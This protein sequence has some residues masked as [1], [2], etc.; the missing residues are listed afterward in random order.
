M[1]ARPNMSGARPRSFASITVPGSADASLSV[2]RSASTVTSRARSASSA[3]HVTIEI[4]DLAAPQGSVASTRGDQSEAGDPTPASTLAMRLKSKSKRFL[5]T[6]IKIYTSF[7]AVS[8]GIKVATNA[9]DVVEAPAGFFL[10]I[11]AGTAR[12][13]GMQVQVSNTAV[14]REYGAFINT[15]TQ[16]VHPTIRFVNTL[17]LDGKRVGGLYER[18]NANAN[19]LDPDVISIDTYNLYL[20]RIAAHEYLHCYTHQNFNNAI[21]D[22]NAG[23]D[24]GTQRK[25]IEG[26]TEY[27]TR[28]TP[29]S[30]SGDPLFV[31]YKAYGDYVKFIKTIVRDI[32]EETLKKAY[33]SGDAESIQKFLEAVRRHSI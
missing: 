33:L 12:A 9:R 14:L 2:S 16:C 32:G 20:P 28:K 27:L 21:Y 13:D 23:L 3:S 29:V 10:T 8:S 15:Q 30:S 4:S 25:I 17:K 18:A 31:I 1:P 24:S 11:F 6:C 7:L 19:G 5:F 26:A 22:R